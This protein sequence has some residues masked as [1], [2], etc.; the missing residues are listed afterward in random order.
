MGIP[1]AELNYANIM[2]ADHC[3]VNIANRSKRWCSRLMH[4]TEFFHPRDVS[5]IFISLTLRAVEVR[6]DLHNG[7]RNGDVE[8]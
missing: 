5:G 3:I 7:A 8:V 4:D 6:E 2:F 1:P